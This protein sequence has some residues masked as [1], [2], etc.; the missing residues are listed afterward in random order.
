MPLSQVKFPCL[1]KAGLSEKCRCL[2]VVSLLE[3]T[4]RL[5]NFPPSSLPGHFK[6]IVYTPTWS[7]SST[8]FGRKTAYWY[9][10]GCCLTLPRFVSEFCTFGS[11]TPKRSAE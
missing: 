1:E 9:L 7:V 5:F 3:Q 8:Q 2:V 4:A 10:P 6:K 11:S